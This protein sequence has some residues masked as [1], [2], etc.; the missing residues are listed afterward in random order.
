MEPEVHI[1]EKYFQEVLHCFT[2]T[3]IKIEGGREIDLLA[4]DP[5]CNIRYHVESRVATSSSH[6]LRMAKSTD[7]GKT[8]KRAVDYFANNKFNH[9]TVMNNVIDIFGSSHYVK[10]LVVWDVDELSVLERAEKEF[11]IKIWFIDDLLEALVNEGKIKGSRDDI[12]RVVELLSLLEKDRLAQKRNSKWNKRRSNKFLR[13]EIALDKEEPPMRIYENYW[14][15]RKFRKHRILC[16]CGQKNWISLRRGIEIEE[17]KIGEFGSIESVYRP[18][19][20]FKCEKC[21]K[22]IAKPKEL[23]R[24]T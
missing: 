19:K 15:W 21:K 8:D 20:A 24:I 17:A 16:I 12:L 5:R 2:M 7:D 18:T 11:S 14:K 6:G 13:Q 1:I 22:L 4:I 23:I 3:N 10:V 9:A